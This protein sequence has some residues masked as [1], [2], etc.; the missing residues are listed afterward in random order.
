MTWRQTTNFAAS[1]GDMN[2]LYFDDRRPEGIIAPP[3]FAFALTWPILS[4]IYDYVALP[5]PPEI[6]STIVHYTEHIE[7]ERPLRPGDEVSIIGEAVALLPHRSGTYV[8]FKL[9]V[10][11]L[12]GRPFHT[13]W[14]GAM[15]R[16]VRCTDGGRGVEN[17]PVVPEVPAAVSP[18]EAVAAGTPVTQ[19]APKPA[20]SAATAPAGG[21]PLWEV[22]VHIGE[23]APYVYDGCTDLVFAIHTSP[24]FAEMVGLPGII[25][26]GTAT[27]SHAVREL[28]NRE[29]GADPTRLEVLSARFR[30]MVRPGTDIRIQLVARSRTGPTH[31]H[32]RVLNSEGREAISRGYARLRQAK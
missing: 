20:T 21:T 18:V 1:V 24:A 15:L 4:R 7:Y 23:E 22:P 13:E 32:F 10:T 8:V 6:M 9:P 3:V 30:A 26:H 5:Y 27:L 12:E 14:I 28:V 2:P 31:L 25:L 16:G 11:D 29:A 17:L 19:A